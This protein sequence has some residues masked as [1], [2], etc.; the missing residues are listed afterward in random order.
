MYGLLC[1]MYNFARRINRQ[2][3]ISGYILSVGVVL[4][5]TWITDFAVP[6]TIIESTLGTIL[7]L[8]FF[9]AIILYWVGLIRQRANDITG[10]HPLLLTFFAIF[11][12]VFYLLFF[13]P[14]ERRAN[15]YG[16]VPRAGLSIT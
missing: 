11:T 12:P 1:F 16:D 13:W 9:T 6:D 7:A 5:L 14:G 3:Y 15:K 10:K 4:I 8:L 2:T